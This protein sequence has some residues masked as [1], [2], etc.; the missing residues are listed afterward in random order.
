MLY[1]S[2]ELIFGQSF[3][4]INACVLQINSWEARKC[5]IL[6]TLGEVGRSN[7]KLLLENPIASSSINTFQAGS[8]TFVV[9]KP[10]PVSCSRC[11]RL[12]HEVD[13]TASSQSMRN[14]DRMVTVY[15][16]TTWRCDEYRMI[17]T[18]LDG[19]RGLHTL[20]VSTRVGG[21][22]YE[23]SLSNSTVVLNT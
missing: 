6:G 10:R 22:N 8:E 4:S 16:S 7:L 15:Y 12:L 3:T 23:L 1:R 21:H 13:S 17:I 2:S 14:L 9:E 19:F 18:C 20:H 11:F 5:T